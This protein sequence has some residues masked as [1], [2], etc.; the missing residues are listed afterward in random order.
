MMVWLQVL[1]QPLV[2]MTVSDS[3][4]FV[5]QPAL[6]VTLTAGELDDSVIVPPPATDQ[7]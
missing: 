3:V 1:K 4:K 6:D 7:L 2:S 5:L